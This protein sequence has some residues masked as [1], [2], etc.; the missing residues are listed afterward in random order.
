MD[1]E[2]DK[3]KKMKSKDKEKIIEKWRK[4]NGGASFNLKEEEII[5]HDGGGFS[6]E[7]TVKYLPRRR[8]KQIKEGPFKGCAEFA[9]IKGPK[10]RHEF[11]DC[12]YSFCD[13]DDTINYLRRMKTMLNDLGY[14]TSS[15]WKR[16]IKANELKGV[17]GRSPTVHPFGE[18][19][20][21]NK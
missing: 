8:L 17:G 11:Y 7:K 14:D 13:L 19:G 10:V 20:G 5:L 1:D 4:N 15:P 16:N 6:I 21:K 9:K 2:V 12:Y 3:R 18:K